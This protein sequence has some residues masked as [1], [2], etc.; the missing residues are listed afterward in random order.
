[1]SDQNRRRSMVGAPPTAK[2]T[3]MVSEKPK[4]GKPVAPVEE[5]ESE[6]S[7]NDNSEVDDE[8]AD[9]QSREPSSPKKRK[10][11]RTRLTDYGGKAKKRAERREREKVEKKEV[12]EPVAESPRKEKETPPEEE[13]ETKP[14]FENYTPFQLLCDCILRKF[15]QKDP[16]EF[17]SQP[18]LASVAPDYHQVIEIP[19][20]FSTMRKKVD[21]NEYSNIEE[22]KKDMSLIFENAIS[23]NKPS[24]IYYLAAQKL[25]SVI[26][27]YFSEHYLEYLRYSLPFGNEIPHEIMG[28]KPKVPIR[29]IAPSTKRDPKI[30]SF[31]AAI[32]DKADVKTVLKQNSA[33]NR[34]KLS[35]RKPNWHLGYIDKKKDGPL[36]LNILTG[37]EKCTV[38]LGDFIGRLDVGTPCLQQNQELFEDFD[39]PV[40]YTDYG[41]FGSFAPQF[42][43]TWATLSKRDSDA[44]TAVYGSK[45]NMA[46]AMT[47]RQMAADSGACLL[48]AVDGILDSLTDGEHSKTMKELEKEPEKEEI[49]PMTKEN[50]VAEPFLRKL[51]DD[52]SSLENIGLDM[53]YLK[54]I[55]VKFGLEP[56][57][58]TA[59]EMLAQSGQMIADLNTLQQNRLNVDPALNLN[60]IS[61]PNQNEVMLAGRV[62]Q[63]LSTGISQFNVPPGSVASTQA[64]HQAIG[65]NDEECDFSLLSEF[66]VIE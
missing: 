32:T 39:S 6:E 13:V 60:D 53:S 19:M 49:E 8:T 50:E 63:Q 44:L 24:T 37:D 23:Y 18:V 9:S 54:E 15:I 46:D 47:L 20:D 65:I 34:T 28:L 31:R 56:K 17:F 35:E 51:L 11:R 3:H 57:E 26:K 59:D 2:R 29:T 22:L 25:Q 27:Y 4:R 64:V 12:S 36:S 61:Q 5:E 33:T 52:V 66:M 62:A 41:P 55:K 10:K 7:S 21:G 16:E 14:R 1:M 30:D 45:K 42:D 38:T 48:K 43:S 40:T 58:P